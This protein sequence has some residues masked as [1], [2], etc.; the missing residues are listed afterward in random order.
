VPDIRKVVDVW[1]A[2]TADLGER[3]RWVQVFE[4]KGA[5]MGFQRWLADSGWMAQR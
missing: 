1:A 3:H 2:Q 5:V 4:N